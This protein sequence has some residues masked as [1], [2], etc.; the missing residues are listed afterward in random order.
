M[1][2]NNPSGTSE[3]TMLD[4]REQ[5]LAATE[6]VLATHGFQGLSMQKVAQQAGIA[7]GT[8]YCHFKDKHDLLI[9][10]AAAIRTRIANQICADVATEGPLYGRYRQLWLN[11]WQF[12][13][14]NPNQINNQ[15]QYDNVP[16][17]SRPLWAEQRERYAVW[18]K[19]LEEGVASG[20]LID[21]PQQVLSTLSLET[22]QG[23]FRRMSIHGDT[24][25]F[26]PQIIEQTIEASW[27]AI[28]RPDKR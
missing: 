2:I 22:A 7:A 4:T 12:C 10:L 5:I 11:L 25:T 16:G 14:Q 18:F 9:Q 21:L 17:F 1:M 6:I 24:T 20:E 23:L 13:C 28:L 19:V 27:R 8:I 26:S 15:Y 3:F